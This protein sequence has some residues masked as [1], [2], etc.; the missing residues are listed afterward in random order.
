MVISL[1][2]EKESNQSQNFRENKGCYADHRDMMNSDRSQVFTEISS[3]QV[4]DILLN[5]QENEKSQPTIFVPFIVLFE[6]KIESDWKNQTRQQ[7]R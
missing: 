1:F 5:T 3:I 4:I 7:R 6:R 2:L